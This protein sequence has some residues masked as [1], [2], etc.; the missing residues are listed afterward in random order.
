M[1]ALR[2]ISYVI[3]VL[4][5]VFLAFLLFKTYR[6]V[7]KA[8][9]Y[10]SFITSQTTEIVNEIDETNKLINEIEFTEGDSYIERLKARRETLSSAFEK[11]RSGL[12]TRGGVE[13]T[14][15]V[16]SEFEKLLSEGDLMLP[17]LDLVISSIE[18]SKEKTEFES[19]IASYELNVLNTETLVSN[20]SNELNNFQN[21]YESFDLKRI[22]NEI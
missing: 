14:Q 18:D 12:V 15:N 8:N 22:L 11:S 21:L 4:C 5:F 6:S 17:N 2:G 13:G 3:L 10:T 7:E 9:E 20:I 19:A 16:N 1:K